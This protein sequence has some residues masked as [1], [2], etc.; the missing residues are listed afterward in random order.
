ML[1][2]SVIEPS[3]IPHYSLIVL[4]KNPT[5]V[6]VFVQICDR[7]TRSQFYCEPIPDPER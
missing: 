2:I 4:V 1:N 7:S 3:D 5:E 6:I